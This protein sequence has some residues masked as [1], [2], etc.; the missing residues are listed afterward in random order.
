MTSPHDTYEKTVA[1]LSGQFRDQ[2]TAHAMLARTTPETLLKAVISELVGEEERGDGRAREWY[3]RLRL[4][5]YTNGLQEP[6]AD[7][8][9]GLPPDHHGT[10]KIRGLPNVI[11]WIAEMASHFHGTSCPG[12]DGRSLGGKLGGLRTMMSNRGD[13]TGVLRADY[14]VMRGDAVQY[15]LA[16]CDVQR[17]GREDDL[18]PEHQFR[19]L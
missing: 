12:L 19:R 5:S 14:Q 8:D 6:L 18:K 11:K 7:T 1:V 16:R 3:V 4:Y 17:V 10:T 15:M 2:L 13:N 9:E